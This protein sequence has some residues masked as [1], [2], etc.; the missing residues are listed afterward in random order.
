MLLTGLFTLLAAPQAGAAPP[1]ST[2]IVDGI[3]YRASDGAVWGCVGGGNWC[4]NAQARPGICGSPAAP[5]KASTAAT[6]VVDGI[7]YLASS[8][9]VVGC[10]GGGNWCAGAPARPGICAKTPAATTLPA[11]MQ[12]L[13]SYAFGYCR[14]SSFT[15]S[16]DR[17]TYMAA[18]ESL[19]AGRIVR[20]DPFG[21]G[22]TIETILA[23]EG[24]FVSIWP[25]E[26]RGVMAFGLGRTAEQ[27][28]KERCR[29][30]KM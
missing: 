9:A 17:V 28:R 23:G 16:A 22:W 20:V 27:S 21:K 4:A 26:E 30:N 6:C 29:V 18:Y 1:P 7:Q 19:G 13:W 15:L 5:A 3:E 14:G 11:G 25:T 10:E 24:K 12:G 2:C 8:G